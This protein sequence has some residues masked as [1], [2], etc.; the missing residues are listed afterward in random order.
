[1]DYNLKLN[2]KKLLKVSFVNSECCLTKISV[3]CDTIIIENNSL[4]T[5][6]AS[7]A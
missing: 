3:Y 4:T 6:T 1:M 5:A 7:G 2:T